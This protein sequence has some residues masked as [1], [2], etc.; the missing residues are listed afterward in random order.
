MAVQVVTVQTPAQRVTETLLV[1]AVTVA[2]AVKVAEAVT[3][4]FCIKCLP[5]VFLVMI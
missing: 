4:L 2:K 1:T 3:L 5:K